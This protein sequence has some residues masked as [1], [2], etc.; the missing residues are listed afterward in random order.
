MKARLMSG[1]LMLT[2]I[3]LLISCGKDPEP[4]AGISFEVEAEEINESDGKLTSFNPQLQAGGIGQDIKVKILFD[5]PLAGKTGDAVCGLRVAARIRD[6][7]CGEVAVGRARELHRHPGGAAPGAD[8]SG[9]VQ[10][11]AGEVRGQV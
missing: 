6:F 8:V 10:R 3:V 11:S 4:N 9:G 7:L 5:K 2:G 1:F